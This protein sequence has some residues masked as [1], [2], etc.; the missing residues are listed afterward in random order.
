MNFQRSDE[1]RLGKECSCGGGGG[2]VWGG[3]GGGCEAAPRRELSVTLAKSLHPL[4]P[5]PASVKCEL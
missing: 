2:E 5:A 3:A 1:R 4:E